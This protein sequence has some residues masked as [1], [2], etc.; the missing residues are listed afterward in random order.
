MVLSSLSVIGNSMRLN[1]HCGRTGQ[2]PAAANKNR[3]L[4]TITPGTSSAHVLLSA[5]AGGRRLTNRNGFEP[6]KIQTKIR[7]QKCTIRDA[8]IPRLVS[9]FQFPHEPESLK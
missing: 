5:Q 2:N 6:P 8:K 1:R 3:D 7:A 9:N 4:P